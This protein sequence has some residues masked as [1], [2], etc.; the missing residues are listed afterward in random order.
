L[1]EALGSDEVKKQLAMTEPRSR[2]GTPED[3][4][5]FI[6]K[7]EKKWSQLLKVAGVEQE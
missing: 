7:D 2:R 6:D 3:Y 1:R 5:D 4:A